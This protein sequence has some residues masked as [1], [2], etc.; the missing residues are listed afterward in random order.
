MIKETPCLYLLVL[1]AFMLTCETVYLHETI[2]NV[3]H[4][5]NGSQA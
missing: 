3:L 2:N 4:D 1:S 5:S